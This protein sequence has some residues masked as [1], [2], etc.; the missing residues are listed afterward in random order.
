MP[1]ILVFLY[2]EILEFVLRFSMRDI[3]LSFFF[4]ITLKYNS[5][6]KSLLSFFDWALTLQQISVNFH[7][8]TW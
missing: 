5:T 4:L 1:F 2:E 7:L 3:L 6:F 8:S